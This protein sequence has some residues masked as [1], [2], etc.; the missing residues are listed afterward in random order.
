LEARNIYGFSVVSNTVSILTAQVPAQPIAPLTTWSPDDVIVTWTAPDNGGSPITGYTVSIKESDLATYTVDLVN[1]DMSS[2]TSVTCTIP[3]T[4]LR[5]TPY[6]LEWGTSVY[7]KVIAINVYGN[8]LESAEGNGAVITTTPDAPINLAENV[9][10]RTKS[11]LA[12]TWENAPFIG[13]AD[14]IDYRI[15][16]AVQGGSYSV[17][18]SGLVNPIYTA[19]GLTAGIIFEFKVESRNSYSFS[20]YS[21]VITL[22]CAYIPEPPLTVTTTNL[23]E[24]VT[25]DWIVPVTNGSPITAYK[26]FVRLNDDVTFTEENVD[27]VVVVATKTCSI[28]LET[29]KA[30]PYDLVKDDSVY[31][32]IISVN[33]YGESELSF[34]GN[35]AVIQLVPDAPITLT[36]DPLTTTDTVIRFTWSDGS[37]DGGTAVIDYSVYYDQ[38]TNNYV[39]LDAAVSTQFYTTLVTL[40]PGVLYSFKVTARNT[41][42]SG[43]LSVALAV[44]AAKLPDAPLNLTNVSEVTTGYQVELSW[45]EGAYDGGSPEIDY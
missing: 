38:G 23:N 35:N 40:I 42:G 3:V 6:S 1:C 34:E 28:T 18:A 9:A 33:L 8:S 25:I 24:L 41:V 15:S 19:T 14:I 44:L 13:G 5:T 4:T 16:I 17:L 43:E 12:L 22:L 2:D 39:L 27:C 7:A 20:A 10:L 26:V 21:D 32:K 11:T 30:T 31:V 29:L 37:S 36:N 45:T